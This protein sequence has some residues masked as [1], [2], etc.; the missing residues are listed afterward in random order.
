MLLLAVTP[1]L[2]QERPEVAEGRREFL[3]H[4]CIQC[5]G[6]TAAGDGPRHT[7]FI[8]PP[9]NLTL[10]H[11]T[12]AMIASI[13]R[14][15]IQGTAMP[16]N[17]VSDTELAE[18]LAFVKAQPLDTFHQWAYP[19]GLRQ[20]TPPPT[21]APALF[22]TT[23]AGCHGTA[24]DGRTAYA[25]DDPHFWPKPANFHARNSQVGRSYHTITTGR[26]GTMMPPQVRNLTTQARWALARY[27]T[28]LFDPRSPDTIP[29]GP[30]QFYKNPYSP[31][32]L[33]V[34]GRGEELYQ[35]Y[36]V[37]CHGE[38]ANGSFLAPR[39][40]DR[41][42]LYGGGTDN[43]AFMVETNGIPGKLIGS[44]SIHDKFTFVEVPK[45]YA[46][47]VLT[48]MKDNQIKGKRINI[49]PANTRR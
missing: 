1:V 16:P 12:P 9:A 25:L 13:I 21:M 30:M 29:T 24:G 37:G 27:V 26:R 48:I 32:N 31:R 44:I 33:A 17:R 46:H 6:P 8:P 34:V 36:C 47:D 39:Q 41:F 20:I 2:A 22:L 49:E 11:D 10:V 19:W 3:E 7:S 38:R 43:A 45:E 15:G 42:W 14:K 23:C 18:L 28:S 5:H 35:L 4:R 40:T